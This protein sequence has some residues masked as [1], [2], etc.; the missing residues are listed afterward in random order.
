MQILEAHH[1]PLWSGTG[2]RIVEL[3]GGI[4]AAYSARLLADFGAD[5]IKVEAPGRGDETRRAGPF[6]G[7]I[8]HLE[9]SGLFLYLNFNKRSVT[10][11]I[12]TGTGATLLAQLLEDANVL[13]ENLGPGR[14]DALPLPDGFPDHLVVCSISGYGQDGPKAGF[15]A[16]EIS[17]YAAG[18]MMYIT[19][20]SNREPVKHG[21]NQAAHLAGVNAAAATLAAA[22]LARRTGVGQTIDIS[23]QEVVAQTIFPALN[24]YSHT[25]GVMKRAPTGLNSLVSSSPMPAADGYIMP[26]YA[27]FGEWGSFAA[28]VEEPELAEERFLTPAGRQEHGAEID[29]LVGPK[30]VARSK[31]DLFH[32]GQEWGFT[33]TAVQTA[34][35]LAD[36]PHL[37]SRGFFIEQHHPVAGTVRMPGMAP[38]ASE[39]ARSPVVPAPLLGQ[40]TAEVMQCL[41]V[42]HEELPALNASGSI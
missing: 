10:V 38:F 33:F 17:A 25:G 36:C 30:F 23:E 5:V 37:A 12:T 13:I 14:L 42:A 20:D 28:F 29:R 34:E 1:V 11:D 27:G 41:A 8:P 40:H 16:S 18:G 4:S 39:V 15:L 21:L 2:L 31:H 6:P 19:G 32:G 9:K 26:S 22:I 35:D 3:G 7:D 24:I